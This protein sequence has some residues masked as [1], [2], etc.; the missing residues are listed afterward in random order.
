MGTVGILLIIA[1]LE[2]AQPRDA[3]QEEVNVAIVLEVGLP[4]APPSQATREL[5]I[6]I[7]RSLERDGSVRLVARE[8]PATATLRILN[9]GPANGERTTSFV[10]RYSISMNGTSSFYEFSTPLNAADHPAVARLVM[11]SVRRN[12]NRIVKWRRS[13]ADSADSKGVKL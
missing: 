12:L 3:G 6:G 4:E 13:P 9:H 2:Q 1:A 5:A 11:E 10:T 8:Q 7:R